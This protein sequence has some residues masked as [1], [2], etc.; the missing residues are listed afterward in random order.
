MKISVITV[1]WNSAA[2]IEET[3]Q[4]VLAQ[5]HKDLEY[6]IIDGASKD[7]TLEIIKKYPIHVVV[8]EPDKGI[9]DAMNKGLARAT[10]DVVAIL[11]S[12][13]IY[14]NNSV[15]SRVAQEFEQQNC[16]ALSTDIEIFKGKPS[17]V[18]R[19]YSCTK[20]KPW[21]FR[22]GAQPPHPG[23]FIRKN[24][25]DKFGFFDTGFKIAADFELMLRFILK[26]HIKVY[27]SPWVSVSMRSGGESQ[28]S[29]RNIARTNYEDHKALRKNGFFSTPP[30]I[31]TKYL[32]KIFQIRF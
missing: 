16:D 32:I 22:I 15:L 5:D 17:Q 6:I 19:Y 30:T 12:D 29:F 14:K 9:Y 8:S 10:G 13:D 27:F 1:A 2:T 11:N 28:R 23:F 24:T 3:I 4:S 31:W 26:H 18:I 7:N 21:M 25:Y 20:W